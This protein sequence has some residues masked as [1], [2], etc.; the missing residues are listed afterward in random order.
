MQYNNELNDA[1]ELYKQN[2]YQGALDIFK[3]VWNQTKELNKW[4]MFRMLWCIYRLHIKSP[5]DDEKLKK[6]IRWIAH[7]AKQENCNNRQNNKIPDPY[8]L[9]VR[10]AIRYF[11]KKQSPNY[12]LLL[13]LTSFL[14]PKILCHESSSRILDGKERE[15]QS[16]AEE[17]YSIRTKALLNVKQYDECIAHCDEALGSFD[18][19]TNG[20][21]IWLL[22]RKAQSLSKTNKFEES[23][24][25]LFDIIEK[26]PDWFIKKDIAYN[27]LGLR[28]INNTQK[29]LIDAALSSAGS[30]LA[31]KLPL[32]QHL[33]DFFEKQ[34]DIESAKPHLELV[35]AIKNT[36]TDWKINKDLESRYKRLGGDTQKLRTPEVLLPILHGIWESIKYK[37]QKK[38]KGEIKTILNNKSGFIRL[39]DNK[40]YHFSFRDV[41]GNKN[42]IKVGCL[43]EFY[44]EKSFHKNKESYIAVAIKVISKP[45]IK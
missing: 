33:A 29:W 27:F 21:Q 36:H 15:Q 5:T 44:L 20:N 10:T 43:V 17:W 25:I 2:D 9:S 34:N 11:K 35:L 8:T 30:E 41:E 23:N 13:E 14:D 4:D 6:T 16:D 26:K 32:F 3:K 18:K 39:T 12:D 28:D 22:R 40:E 37:G 7:N 19:F 42:K 45:C 31:M 1:A 24:R 38:I